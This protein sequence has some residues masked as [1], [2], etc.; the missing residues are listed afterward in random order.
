MADKIQELTNKIYQEGVEKANVEAKKIVTEAQAE[1]TK[2]ISDAK[3]QAEELLSAAQRD[4]NELDKSTRAEIKMYAN[5]SLN[6]LKTE[7]TNLITDKL[8]KIPVQ[9]F[10]K[11]KDFF[12][13]FMVELAS[14]W[15]V[16]E[17]IVISTKEAESLKEYFA[18]NAKELLDKGIKI[19]KVNNID[20]LFSISPIDGSYKVNFGE[21]E[22]INYFK[23]FLRP[24]L[25]EMIF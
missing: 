16:D 17:P 25:I 13:K 3:K 9:N 10:V 23:E 21:D 2:I 6:A 5:Q 7:I 20:V 14:K 15:S 11:D 12:N 1:A 8:V 22:F 24:Q 18:A 19:E 4:S